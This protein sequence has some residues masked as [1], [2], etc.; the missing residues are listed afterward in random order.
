[1]SE[2]FKAIT[3]QEEFDK[4]IADRLSRQKETILKK[5]EG[6]EEI[7]AEKARVIQGQ[8]YKCALVYVNIGSKDAMLLEIYVRR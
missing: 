7:K 6:F 3:T 8:D 5:Y 1:M 2:E 4:A